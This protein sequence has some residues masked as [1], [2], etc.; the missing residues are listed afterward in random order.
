MWPDG[1]CCGVVGAFVGGLVQSGVS[2]VTGVYGVVRHPINTAKAL[3]NVVAHPINTAKAIGKAVSNGYDDFKN[4][5]ANTK[6]NIAGNVIGDVAQA[7]IGTEE[8]KAATETVKA[9][10]VAGDVGKVSEA[11]DVAKSSEY[12]D[13]S[14]KNSVRNVQTDVTPGEF[15]SNLEQSGF[16]K[17]TTADGK[18]TTYTKGDAKYSVHESPQT[19]RGTAGASATY[20]N[21]AKKVTTKIRLNGGN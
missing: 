11:A 16:N 18:A 3:G 9:A 1:G 13:I 15:G 19:S 4:G 21:G 8:V 6:A 17:A 14:G 10:E 7:F 5:D 12:I 20:S 2:T